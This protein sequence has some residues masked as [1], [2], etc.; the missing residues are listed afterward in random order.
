MYFNIGLWG[1]PKT[2]GTTYEGLLIAYAE[3]IQYEPSMMSQGKTP[4]KDPQ[5]GF[6][7]SA[8]LS[9]ASLSPE[10]TPQTPVNPTQGCFQGSFPGTSLTVYTV[11]RYIVG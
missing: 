5:V 11:S 7:G 10:K 6:K 8:G 2:S 4:W 9:K 3:Y 1:N